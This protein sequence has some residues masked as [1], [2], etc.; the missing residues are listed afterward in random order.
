ML[1]DAN[2]LT[3]STPFPG[4]VDAY[5]RGVRGLLGWHRDTIGFFEDALGRDPGFAI[6]HA[7]HAVSLFVEERFAEARA[8]AERARSLATGVSGRERSQ[9]E[10]L[11]LYVNVRMADAEAV[12]RQHLAE[13]PRDLLVAQR[14]YF[15]WFFQGRMDEMFALTRDLMAAAP[16][17]SYPKG[18]HAFALEEL[19][20]TAEALPIAER[21]VAENAEDTWGIHALAHVLYEMGAWGEGLARVPPA[22][23]AN[24]SMNYYRNHLLGPLVLLGR[25]RGEYERASAMTRDIF[26]REP[27]PLALDLRNSISLLWR[28]EICGM[29]VQARWRPFATI[30]TRFMN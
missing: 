8:A 3:A 22:L 12:M 20:H 14:L 2:G 30:A 15:I 17:S 19:G 6:A 18:L 7:G 26:E 16:D 27:S 21:S 23:A 13:H 25:A 5:N 28:F 29:D 11:T 9:I 1:Q 4:A 24:P 10:A